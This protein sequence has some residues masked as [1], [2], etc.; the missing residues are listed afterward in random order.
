MIDSS[1]CVKC[2]DNRK[3]HKYETVW[4]SDWHKYFCVDCYKVVK[5]KPFRYERHERLSND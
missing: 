4:S 3:K 1:N 5:E 2:N